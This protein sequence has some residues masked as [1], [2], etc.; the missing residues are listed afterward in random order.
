MLMSK[1]ELIQDLEF[2]QKSSGS[3]AD[4]RVT[5]L[6]FFCKFG[7]EFENIIHEE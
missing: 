5:C 1:L 2:H 3:T 7:Y 6:I 4:L